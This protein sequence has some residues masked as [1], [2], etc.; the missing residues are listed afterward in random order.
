MSELQPVSFRKGRAHEPRLSE[1]RVPGKR[2]E[3]F[4]TEEEN[5]IIKAHYPN[6]GAAAVLARLPS[7][8]LSGVYGQA[9]KLG[10]AATRVDRIT[11]PKGFDDKLRALYEQGD[12]RKKGELNAFADE[13][14]LPRWWITKRAT[15][16][17]LVIPHKKEPPW[18]A[19]ENE[20]MKRVP[21]HNPDRCAELFREH[22][23]AR[24]ATAIMVRA[25]RLDLSRRF[26]ETLSATAVSKILG[27]DSKGVTAECING[28]LEASKRQTRR[29]NQQGGDPWSIEPAALRAYIIEHLERIDLRKVEK[30]AFIQIVAGE[31]L[32]KHA[33][34]KA[35]AA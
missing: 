22:G 15:K 11:A 24:S 32:E 18:T 21:L 28:R 5:A 33:R 31:P 9:K 14:K 10:A 23:F 4:W 25:K 16:L 7:R 20:L 6:G 3:R 35:E 1:P 29:L 17:G 13:H 26:R 12:G 30:F 8:T 19:A 34:G 2:H 27:I